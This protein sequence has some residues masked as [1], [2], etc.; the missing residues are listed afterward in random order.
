MKIVYIA[1]PFR[2]HTAW[3]IAENVRAA[4]RLGLEVCKLGLMALIPHANTA[5]FHG[6]LT[7]DFFLDGTME[8]LRRSDAV[9]LLPDW[10]KSIGTVREVSEAKK[11]EIP[12]FQEIEDLLRWAAPGARSLPARAFRPGF[13]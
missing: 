10:G 4:E 7:E 6:E 3:G 2:A 8:L 5:H 12:V 13:S 1:G 9:M 11:L